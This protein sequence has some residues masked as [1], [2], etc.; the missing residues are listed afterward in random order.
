MDGV[1]ASFVDE[2][3]AW[4]PA[5]TKRLSGTFGRQPEYMP[6]GYYNDKEQVAERRHKREI[7]DMMRVTEKPFKPASSATNYKTGHGADLGVLNSVAQTSVM[8][9]PRNIENTHFPS[10]SGINRKTS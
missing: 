9:H 2:R 10:E 5:S 4:K 1:Q 7:S 3:S 6:A 8:M